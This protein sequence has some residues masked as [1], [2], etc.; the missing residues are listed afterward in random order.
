MLPP[1]PCLR[2]RGR[3]LEPGRQG[4]LPRQWN[5]LVRYRGSQRGDRFRRLYDADPG[6]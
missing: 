5:H 2:T 6:H 4:V 3:I 1:S